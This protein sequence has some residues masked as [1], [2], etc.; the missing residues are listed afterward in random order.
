MHKLYL[1]R[2]AVNLKN[3]SRCPIRKCLF[4]IRKGL[5]YTLVFLAL[6]A[7]PAIAQAR[8]REIAAFTWDRARIEVTSTPD[9]VQ[10]VA[11]R[12]PEFVMIYLSVNATTKFADSAEQLL[13]AKLPA[14][15]PGETVKYSASSGDG[16]PDFTFTRTLK[17]SRSAHDLYFA[18]QYVVNTISI[19]VTADRTKAFIAALRRAAAAAVAMGGKKAE[20][21][22]SQ[23]Y[24]EFQIEKP[25]TLLASS[26]RLVYPETLTGSGLAG[27]VQAQFV[28][29]GDGTVDVS[30]FKVLRSTN[31]VFTQS[32]RKILPELRYAPAMIGDREVNQ[33]VQQ[34]FQ[35]SR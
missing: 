18:D 9:Q 3:A 35:F 13:Q 4:H 17:G 21:P 8:S 26:I 33:L 10:V 2:K 32:V 20:P 29:R 5:F 31:E 27:E 16:A 14:P 6:S 28:V 19:D 12:H 24:F 25:A 11:F 7:M 15:E 1:I 30:T 34:S 23:T 22:P